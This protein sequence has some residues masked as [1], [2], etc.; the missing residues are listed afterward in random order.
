M[1]KAGD[2]KKIIIIVAFIVLFLVLPLENI[3]AYSTEVDKMIAD[4]N[5]TRAAL[6]GSLNRNGIT[7]EQKEN[8]NKEIQNIDKK[9]SDPESLQKQVDADRAALAKSSSSVSAESGCS[10]WHFSPGS[11]LLEMINWSFALTSGAVSSVF[12]VIGGK[13]LDISVYMSI[14]MMKS[15]LEM[16]GVVYVWTIARDL[17]NMILIFILLYAAFNVIIDRST[18]GDPKKLITAVIIVALMVNFS[19]FFVRAIVDVSNVLSYEFYKVLSNGSEG[20]RGWGVGGN[21]LSKLEAGKLIKAS[22]D[23][24]IESY[25]NATQNMSLMTILGNFIFGTLFSIFAAFIL[26]YIAILFI[27]RTITIVG[28]F[29]IS[30]L[31]VLAYA[32]PGQKNKFYSF[33]K[34]LLDQAIFGP[35]MLFMLY[36][37]LKIMEKG[38]P[39][40]PEDYAGLPGALYGGSLT[41]IV[42]YLIIFGLLIKSIS[43]AKELGA[44]GADLAKSYA[45]K[46]TGAMVG[47]GGAAVGYSLK[48][49]PIATKMRSGYNRLYNS[50]N[51]FGRTTRA[52][53][54]SS[55][56]QA[57]GGFA[58]SPLTKSLSA[59]GKRNPIDM[60]TAETW[61]KFYDNS[62][63]KYESQ[64]EERTFGKDGAKFNDEQVLMNFLGMNSTEREYAYEKMS[65]KQRGLIEHTLNNSNNNSVKEDVIKSLLKAE[66]LDDATINT[67]SDPE[68]QN[69]AKEKAKEK[70]ET[71]NEKL[72]TVLGEEN[73]RGVRSDITKFKTKLSGKDKGEITKV[74]RTNEIKYR[75]GDGK[76]LAKQIIS[77]NASG[78]LIEEEPITVNNLRDKDNSP[79]NRDEN[80]ASIRSISND[81]IVS[82]FEENPNDFVNSNIIPF[83]TAKQLKA[84]AGSPAMDKA[85]GD[86]IIQKIEE[87][88]NETYPPRSNN[89]KNI[90]N[91]MKFIEKNQDLF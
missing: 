22:T 40:I 43:L 61:S 13:I 56:G 63:N 83:I 12:L 8:I 21:F 52:I 23:M 33:T 78:T 71:I 86:K 53:S 89:D 51:M 48:K 45:G 74:I 28:L 82:L 90:K 11:C 7:D 66:K 44:V 76:N 84:L 65:E 50:N 19:G 29:M 88:D 17:A 77:A 4:L 32:V 80:I 38:I 31:V 6:V 57:I 91:V 37:I 14:D 68:A 69:S 49:S 25:G 10:L 67:I 35:V 79:T 87:Y 15:L 47:L 75:S 24:N 3:F 72:N 39:S 2:H 42:F 64:I 41:S 58:R 34:T 5:T 46:A 20:L 81:D 73:V 30:P 54:R 18:G 36:A 9:L 26:I 59:F 85:K 60:K 70:R 62:K 16:Q 1:R 27:I 55:T